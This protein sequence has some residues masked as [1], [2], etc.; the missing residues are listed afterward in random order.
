MA[1]HAVQKHAVFARRPPAS[2][3]TRGE[4]LLG[5]AFALWAVVG[6]F[7]DGWAH[8]ERKPDTF[9]TPWHG[10]L[11]SGF[12]LAAGLTL[13]VIYRRREAG[14]S[15]RAA[16]PAGQITTL[17]GFGV[18]AIGAFGDLVWHEVFGIEVS[19]EA[20]LSPTHLFLMFGGLVALSAPLRAAWRSSERTLGLGAFLPAVTSL[21]LITAVVAFFFTYVSP[22][23]FPGAVAFPSTQSDIHDLSRLTPAL[24]AQLRE[25]WVLGGFLV[26]TVVLTVPALAVLKRWRP[27]FGTFTTLFTSVIVFEAALG[28]FEQPLLIACGAATGV[29]ADVIS[30]RGGNAVVVGFAIPCVLWATY[31]AVSAVSYE[32]AWSAE[33]WSGITLMSAFVGAGLGALADAEF[34]NRLNSSGSTNS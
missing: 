4:E 34:G 29:A 6:L 3:I 30:S 11:Y 1:Q 15:W 18:F 28:Q 27:P 13:L 33:L 21:T 2:P 12:T 23:H 16:A 9:F 24:A 10:V 7:F 22:F 14:V 31:F 20:L 25:Q 26:T 5:I 19:I 17:F 32:L 8:S